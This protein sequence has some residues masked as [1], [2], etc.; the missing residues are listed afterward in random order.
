MRSSHYLI[1]ILTAAL[2][3][4]ASSATAQQKVSPAVPGFGAVNTIP[5]AVKKPDPQLEYKVLI[6]VH[7]AADKPEAIVPGLTHTARMLN[8]HKLGG[9]P[10]ENMQ[11]VLVVHGPAL[12]LVLTNEAYR[13]KFGMDNP[14]TPIIDALKKA[15]VQLFV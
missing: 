15:G 12:P 5:A 9:V 14:N 6:D 7:E 1:I 10:E 4:V 11:V 8:L 2:L 13:S 3:T